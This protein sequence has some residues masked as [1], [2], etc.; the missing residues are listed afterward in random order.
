ML[1]ATI[2]NI[3]NR[4]LPR[5]PRAR[6]ICAQLAGR[7]LAVEVRG[8]ADFLLSSDGSALKVISGRGGADA[9]RGGADGGRPD[10]D[11]RVSG[12]PF[13]LLA[14]AGP[15]APSTLRRA[16]VQIEGDGDVAEQF[17]EL[18]RRVAPDLEEELAL[19]IGDVP[20]HEIARLARATLGWCRG[21]VETTLRNLA[22]YLAHERGD[23]VSSAEGRQL[24]TGI[25]AVRED[26]DRLEARLEALAR[27]IQTGRQEQRE[28]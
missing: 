9:G 28:A 20:A 16:D 19:A 3:L 5:S 1:A 6:E 11:A 17:H 4:G 24:L 10:A 14:L 25:D 23:L 8:I 27:R 15:G 13:S 7:R 26:V 12:G 22:E 18:V 21:A 2:E